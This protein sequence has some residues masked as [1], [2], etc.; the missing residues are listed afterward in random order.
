[1]AKEFKK[2]FMHPTRRKLM[3]MVQTG[4]YDKNTTIGWS[5]KKESHDIGDVWE[6]EHYKYEQKDGYVV[7]QG[8]NSEIFEGIRKYLAS[9]E[10]CSNKECTHVGKFNENHKSSIKEFG[11][12]INC[13][14]SL[15]IELK[16]HDIYDDY[17]AYR[18]YTHRIKSGLFKLE[19]I[20][21]S[22][23]ELKQ[24]YDEINEKGDVVNSYVLPRPVDDMKSEMEEFIEKS[25]LEIDEISKKRNLHIEQIRKKNYEHIL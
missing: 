14:S 2:N 11:Y 21:Q 23:D 8:K 17:V 7:K 10:K 16:E 20:R 9:L 22:M 24:S 6:D 12:C 15:E 25:K 18:I 5:A 1:M 4:E 19:E 3:D 13:M